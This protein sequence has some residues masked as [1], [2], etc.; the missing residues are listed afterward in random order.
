M[1]IR[2]QGFKDQSVESHR[3]EA[4]LTFFGQRQPS[5]SGVIKILAAESR[6]D[7]FNVKRACPAAR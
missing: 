2:P 4:G 5:V 7:G 3:S 1:S 6:E